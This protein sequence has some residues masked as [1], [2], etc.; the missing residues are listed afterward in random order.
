MVAMRLVFCG[1]PQFAV[2]TFHAL[3]DAGHSIE[4]ALVQPDRAAGRGLA[5]RSAPVKQA[6]LDRGIPVAQ[7]T[8]LRDNPELQQ[9][10]SAIAP[11]AIIVVA[12]GRIIPPW[13]LTLPP[14][15]NLNL[16]ASLLPKYRGA[17]PIQW[18]IASGETETG[19]T[20]MHLEE[21]LDTG[22]ILLQRR[23]PIGADQTA[24][25]LFPV[26][27]SVG[28]ALMVETLAGL[29]AGALR[30]TAQDSN[31][32]TLAPIL[33]REDGRIDWTRPAQQIYNRWRGFQPW[34]GA[35]TRFRGKNLTLHAIR[36]AAEPQLSAPP[37]TLHRLPGKTTVTC[38][39]GT[40]LELLEVQMEGKRRMPVADFLNGY[41]L[42]AGERL[43]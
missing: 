15:G 37:G 42:L 4:L 21:G 43:G 28:A 27:A 20:T 11:E 33:T 13:M 16:H 6:A 17:A 26:L 2:P 9:Q 19:V 41:P 38:G 30:P 29:A 35:F 23:V 7:P 40:A 32:A 12:Y 3:L 1:T 5:T 22:G 25:D 8:K 18:A 36:P 14:H 34:P 10:L 31:Q 24:A 39:H